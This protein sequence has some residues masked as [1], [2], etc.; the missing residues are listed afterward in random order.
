MG[1]G[2]SGPLRWRRLWLTFPRFWLADCRGRS[3][4]NI[5]EVEGLQA[6]NILNLLWPL[7]DAISNC[8]VQSALMAKKTLETLKVISFPQFKLIL[9]LSCWCS[10]DP[11]ECCRMCEHPAESKQWAGWIHQ[12]EIGF[13]CQPPANQTNSNSVKSSTKRSSCST[14]PE[15]GK[16]FE[17]LRL[18]GYI[19]VCKSPLPWTALHHSVEPSANVNLARCAAVSVVASFGAVGRWKMYHTWRRV[20]YNDVM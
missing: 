1:S 2:T 20:S 14:K 4:L 17:F 5:S 8:H 16:I 6:K 7:Y 19:G 11:W 15:T 12:L 9:V 13:F 10:K 3:L 18:F